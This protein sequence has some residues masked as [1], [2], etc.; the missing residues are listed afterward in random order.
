MEKATLTRNHYCW[1][2][3]QELINSKSNSKK[4]S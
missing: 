3:Y 4:G 1:Y 2:Y